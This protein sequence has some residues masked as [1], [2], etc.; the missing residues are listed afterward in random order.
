M[1]V[2]IVLE[3]TQWKVRIFF[4]KTLLSCVPIKR[5]NIKIFH[6]QKQI[7][8]ENFRLNFKN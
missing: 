8:N 7:H 5:F 2:D 1:I 4:P 6:G 3:N